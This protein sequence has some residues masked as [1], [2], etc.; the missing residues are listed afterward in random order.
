MGVLIL[1]DVLTCFHI[2]GYIISLLIFH[3]QPTFVYRNSVKTSEN[4]YVGLTL[5]EQINVP[6]WTEL[7]IYF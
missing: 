5:W 3:L 1:Q 2:P 4:V 7:A 6:R